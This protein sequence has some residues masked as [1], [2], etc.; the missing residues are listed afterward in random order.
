MG[1][2]HLPLC[3]DLDGTLAYDTSWCLS[4]GIL[5]KNPFFLLKTLFL[6]G[7][8]GSLWFKEAIS[9]KEVLLPENIFYHQSFL[10][11][12][13]EQDKKKRPLF[14]V[15]GAPEPVATAVATDLGIFQGVWSSTPSVNL[16]GPHKA[17]ALTK[18]FGKKNF[19]YAGNSFQDIPVWEQAACGVVVN[20]DRGLIKAL[21]KSCAPQPFILYP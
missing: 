4:S 9:H 7:F 6:L 15:T 5:K 2:C 20:P 3:V 17:R 10:Q 13:L 18:Y 11:D 12:L 21:K 1:P 16:V 14:L 19:V 8:K